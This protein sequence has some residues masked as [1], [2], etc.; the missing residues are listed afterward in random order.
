MT[1]GHNGQDPPTVLA[2][3]SL[4]GRHLAT[5]GRDP[6]SSVHHKMSPTLS[7]NCSRLPVSG[8]SKLT[9]NVL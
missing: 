2:C 5:A 9:G 6:P 1:S 7:D 3:R 8:K 4:L